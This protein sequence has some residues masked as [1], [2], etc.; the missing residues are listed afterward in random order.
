MRLKRYKRF[1]ES[2]QNNLISML[3]Q[4]DGFDKKIDEDDEMTTLTINLPGNIQLEQVESLFLQISDIEKHFPDVTWL[5]DDG[6]F[7]FEFYV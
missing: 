2:N 6:D 3:N 7:I 5:Y 1:V 4:I